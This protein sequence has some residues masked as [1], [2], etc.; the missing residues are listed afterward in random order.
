MH[1]ER[2]QIKAL[3]ALGGLA[4]FF[5][6]GLWLPHFV[7]EHSI[8]DRIAA[9]KAELEQDRGASR[10]LT[11]LAKEVG[12]IKQIVDNAPKYVPQQDEQAE[13]LRQLT[14]EL[15]NQHVADQETLTQPV[16][17]GTDYSMLPLTLN[18]RGEFPAVF[19]FLKNV[20]AMPRMVQVNNLSL[21]APTGKLGQP[22]TVRIELCTF[23]A[24]STETRTP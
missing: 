13:M 17:N 22:L 11:N 12:Q 24:P 14:T 3:L 18:F 23:F 21:Q 2:D 8:Q 4:A 5:V 6:V 16:V 19:N 20:E 15:T 9:L 7:Q 10:G 1:I